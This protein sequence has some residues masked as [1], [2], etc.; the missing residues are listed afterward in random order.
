MSVWTLVFMVSFSKSHDQ[1]CRNRLHT[2]TQTLSTP[3]TSGLL[4]ILS[5]IQC[6]VWLFLPIISGYF[7]ILT[8]FLLTFCIFS[9]GLWP[10]AW[11]FPPPYSSLY[12]EV[13]LL[14]DPK[15][16]GSKINHYIIIC[17]YS[18][19]VSDLVTHMLLLNAQWK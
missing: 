13:C 12:P 6:C 16:T 8:G 19:L 5:N 10:M 18:K 1:S 14:G 3:F 4:D 7:S 11:V 2:T 15:S 17:P 9:S